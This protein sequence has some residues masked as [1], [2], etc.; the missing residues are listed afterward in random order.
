[1][2]LSSVFKVSILLLIC[3]GITACGNRRSGTPPATVPPEQY[4]ANNPETAGFTSAGGYTIWDVFGPNKTD[5]TVNVNRYLWTASLDVLSFLPVTDV[6][7]FTGVIITGFAPRPAVAAL[8]AR[9]CIS[10]TPHLMPARSSWR[11]TPAAAPSA[12]QQPA[13]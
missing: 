5:Q 3:I 4:L 6:D 2:K 13:P 1:M 10:A 8:I 11:C 9:P 7:P 12:P